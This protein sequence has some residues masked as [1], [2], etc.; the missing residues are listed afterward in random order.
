MPVYPPNP[1]KLKF[2]L[3]K[4]QLIV[5]SSGA[6]V[7]LCDDILLTLKTIQSAN[8]FGPKWPKQ[9]KWESTEKWKV[10][11]ENSYDCPDS[12]NSDIAFLQYTS[13][14]TGDPK[15]VMVTY[16]NLE[17]N[18][19]SCIMAALN[20][21]VFHNLERLNA[22]PGKYHEGN[23]IEYPIGVS[24]LPQ[25]HDMGLI[26]GLLTPFI[27]GFRMYHFSPMTFIKNPLLWVRTIS[28][29]HASFTTAPNFALGLCARR[30][31]SMKPALKEKETLDMSSLQVVQLGGDPVQ[32]DMVEAFTNAFTPYGLRDNWAGPS[33]G[34]A[35]HTVASSYSPFIITSTSQDIVHVASGSDV[36]DYIDVRIVNPDTF[37]ECKE[38][39][40]G[41]IWISSRSCAMGYWGRDDATEETFRAKMAS[42]DREPVHGNGIYMR[43]GDA[44]FMENGH[45]FIC[46]RYKDL[47]ILRGKNYYP[48]DVEIVVEK[49]STYVK[50]GC[51]A[52]FS[53]EIEGFD[54]EQIIIVFEWKGSV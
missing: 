39:E 52:V 17:H 21:N 40:Q 34:L 46:G 6:T 35:E 31:T 2:S 29:V 33:Y 30:W 16:G 47:I 4:L 20:R 13:G 11:V 26:V 48:N 32:L 18:I 8:I 43:T 37:M 49:A 15:G 36:E 7:C 27:R 23:I 28:R 10:D 54:D 24:W 41:E 14:S 51:L 3:E 42:P 22:G 45:L 5:D 1:T 53:C 50:P 9:L 25:Y 12:I 19:N 38:T 44:G